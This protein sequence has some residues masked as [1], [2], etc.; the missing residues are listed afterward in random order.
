MYI[1]EKYKIAECKKNEKD[2][3]HE[4][5]KLSDAPD[6]VYYV[7]DISIIN[8]YKNIAVIGSRKISSSGSKLAFDTGNMVGESGIN[9][10]NGLALGCD[11]EALRGSLAAGGRCVAIMPCG[12]E[13]I[14]P[15][16][17]EKLAKEIIDKGGCLLSEYPEGTKLQKYQYVQRDRLQS[18]I[19]QGVVII[20]AEE[21]SGTM[22]TA[23]FA[24]KQSK[25]LAC[26]YYKLLELASGNKYL[27]DTGKAQIL[28]S[29]RDAQNFID[30]IS[31]ET[32]FEQLSLDTL[33][34][35]EK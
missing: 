5:R 13:Q 4:L 33:L 8:K 1:C 28:K 30:E 9:L 21:K 29:M 6:I 16:S 24:Q 15:K 26:Y 10:V 23:N 18:G 14:Q 12:L 19:S 31:E 34:F 3:P 32:E 17:N 27:E 22:H 20:E 2:Y 7:G 11:T 25:R 35:H